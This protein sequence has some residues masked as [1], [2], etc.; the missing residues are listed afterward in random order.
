[1]SFAVTFTEEFYVL[2]FNNFSLVLSSDMN[3]TVF[4]RKTTTPS[5]GAKLRPKSCFVS[6]SEHLLGAELAQTSLTNRSSIAQRLALLKQSGEEGWKNRVQKADVEKEIIT[7]AIATTE[8]EVRLRP[9]KATDTGDGALRGSVITNR[10]SC[11]IDS[12]SGWKN[13]VNES[14]AKQFTVASKQS[15][16]STLVGAAGTANNSHAD[17]QSMDPTEKVVLRGTPKRLGLRGCTLNESALNAVSSKLN[18]VL[19][20]D[21]GMLSGPPRK[22]ADDPLPTPS[23]VVLD[24]SKADAPKLKRTP[25]LNSPTRINTTTSS[26]QPATVYL[27]RPDDEDSFGS[28]FEL[29]SSKLDQLLNK[30]EAKTPEPSLILLDSFSNEP[31][32]L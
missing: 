24:A 22:K 17:V 5:D 16:H 1:M 13:R 25:S 26:T 19:R 21:K 27:S 23:P 12:Q 4:R 30:H 29:D 31:T 6:S 20:P 14:D 10:L 11:L 18:N 3:L 7:T 32:S 9:K 8:E 2:Y 15:R 28:F